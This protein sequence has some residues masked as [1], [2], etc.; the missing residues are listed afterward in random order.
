MD[1]LDQQTGK[2]MGTWNVII[3]KPVQVPVGTYR[4]KFP[5]FTVDNVVVEAGQKVAIE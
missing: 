3:K 4:L 1:I 2:E 5:N